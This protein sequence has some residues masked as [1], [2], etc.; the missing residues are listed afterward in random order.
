MIEIYRIETNGEKTIM[1]R[2]PYLKSLEHAQARAKWYEE[3][4]KNYGLPRKFI[5]VERG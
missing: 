5:V 1:E 2:S 4:Y 3:L